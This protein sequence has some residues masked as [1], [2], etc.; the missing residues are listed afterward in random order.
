[1]E[2][3]AKRRGPGIP[4]SPPDEVTLR[5]GPRESDVKESQVLGQQFLFGL[6]SVPIVFRIDY[7]IEFPVV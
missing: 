2:K 5:P 1:M 6:Q 3:I 7:D 4:E